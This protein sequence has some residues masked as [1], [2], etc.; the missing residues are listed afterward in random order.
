MVFSKSLTTKNTLQQTLSKTFFLKKTSYK[1]WF[2]PIYTNSPTH[3]FDF[4]IKILIIFI[5][6]KL[7]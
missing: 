7:F 6:N 2:H 1:T 4:V 5:K 3:K